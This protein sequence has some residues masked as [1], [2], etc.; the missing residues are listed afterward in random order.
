MDVQSNL[1]YGC[2][3][4]FA[5]VVAGDLLL[6]EGP[7]VSYGSYQGLIQR[8]QCPTCRFL[9]FKIKENADNVLKFIGVVNARVDLQLTNLPDGGHLM[10]VGCESARL[11]YP[12]E[13]GANATP[14][15]E[16]GL[17]SPDGSRIDSELVRNFI[18]A[19]CGEHE[20]HRV[21]NGCGYIKQSDMN[22]L[23]VDVVD[24]CIVRSKQ[25]CR[26]LALSYV[27]GQCKVFH[28]T[29]QNFDDLHI[30]GSLDKADL[31]NVME[32]AIELVKQLGERYL[33]IDAL[34]IV[35]DD[36]ENTMF[37]VDRMDKVYSQALL[38]IVAASGTRALD[39]LPWKLVEGGY[40]FSSLP[41][42]RA[43]SDICYVCLVV[44]WDSGMP[45]SS[46]V[47]QT[48]ERIGVAYITEGLWNTAEAREQRVSLI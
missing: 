26:Y 16:H 28:L 34:C 13:N 22:L 4:L 7:W 12:L 33:W 17:D 2:Q 35:Q 41:G 9:T 45:S 21:T 27:W 18:A 36:T 3:T 48:C 30:P 47:G 23:L 40:Y 29:K 42:L 37:Y 14:Q 46:E 11:D 44:R 15:P 39:A 19:C 31:P 10:R 5:P 43:A 25:H 24:G 6:G 38:T 32:D 8:T 20:G 1:C